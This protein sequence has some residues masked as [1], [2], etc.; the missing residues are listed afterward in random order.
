M[1]KLVNLLLEFRDAK[2]ILDVDPR[3]EFL[4]LCFK[5][6]EMSKSQ[7]FQD[8][9]VLYI[10]KEKRNGFFVEFGAASGINLSNTYLLEKEYGWSGCLAEPGKSWHASYARPDRQCAVDFRCITD[11]TGSVVEFT[12]A[13]SGEL[14]TMSDFLD[15]DNH[16]E[17][18]RNGLKYSVET[19]SLEDFLVD[20][21][22][23]VDIDYLS[24]DTEGSEFMILN[25]FDFSKYRIKILTVEHN[26]C[27]PD[28]EDI[29]G[30]LSSKGFVRIFENISQFDD[31]Y[32]NTKYCQ[33][34]RAVATP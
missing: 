8:L 25:G 34:P 4:Q 14:S 21:N 23:P 1:H 32:V 15:R 19:V 10:L 7:L 27:S 26:Y 5:K 31:W 28:R 12:E 18:R 17:S 13:A 2:R 29:F 3:Y 22:A 6:F 30:L 33:I 16:A 11:K 9:F 20:H 24:I